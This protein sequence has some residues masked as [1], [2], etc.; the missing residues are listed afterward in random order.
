MKKDKN[1]KTGKFSVFLIVID[2]IAVVCFFVVY[3][4][5][6]KNAGIRLHFR[7]GEG[8]C[9]DAR[10]RTGVRG[11]AQL[12]GGRRQSEPAALLG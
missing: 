2:V 9:A 7:E 3:G 4:P 11:V 6:S 1:K 12:R 5:F 10:V 8:V